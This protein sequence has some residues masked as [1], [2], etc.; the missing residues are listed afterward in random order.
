MRGGAVGRSRSRPLFARRSGELDA[1]HVLRALAILGVALL[2]IREAAAATGALPYGVFSE[3]AERVFLNLGSSLDLFFLLSGFLMYASL[4]ALRESDGRLRTGVFWAH[5]AFRILPAY[6][7]FLLLMGWLTAS[8]SG[9]PARTWSAVL[10]D[11]FFISNYTHAGGHLHVWS[12]CVEAHFYLLVPWFAALLLFRLKS[13]GRWMALGFAWLLPGLF[14]AGLAFLAFDGEPNHMEHNLWIYRATH[15]RIDSLVAGMAV[16]EIWRGRLVWLSDR[17]WQ[18]T[19]ALLGGANLLGGHWLRPEDDPAVFAVL[20]YTAFQMGFGC[21]MLALLGRTEARSPDGGPRRPG[22]VAAVLRRVASL[23]MAWVRAV[24]RLS[25]SFY[26]WHLVAAGL[27]LS[28]MLRAFPA[29]KGLAGAAQQAGPA[30]GDGLAAALLL[31]ALYAGGCAA[32]LL[33]AFISYWLI[34]RPGWQL[35]D[36]LLHSSRASSNPPGA[37]E[38]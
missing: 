21:W 9:A 19:L 26:L 33:A 24:A 3:A 18:A 34:E 27:A 1:L 13:R 7:H 17:R 11:L 12:L 20:R 4:V 36:R 10:Q 8:S 38:S 14:R 29:L 5:R 16:Y 30:G 22:R 35:R 32:G 28:Q 31:A 2:H 23:A 15:T 25:Y 37:N 6:A